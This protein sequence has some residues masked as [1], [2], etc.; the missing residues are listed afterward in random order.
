MGADPSGSRDP[1]ALNQFVEEMKESDPVPDRR[2]LVPVER[3]YRLDEEMKT[4]IFEAAWTA[5]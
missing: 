1:Y 5:L 3:N 2:G 4:E